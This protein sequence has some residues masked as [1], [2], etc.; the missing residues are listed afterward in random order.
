MRHPQGLRLANLLLAS[1]SVGGIVTAVQFWIRPLEGGPESALLATLAC[2]ISL[3]LTAIA[4]IATFLAI[5][6]SDRTRVIQT[7]LSVCLLLTFPIGTA[8][9]LYTLWACWSREQRTKPQRWPEA[10]ASNRPFRF[11]PR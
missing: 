1:A 9:S 3:S 11:V 4:A 5:G 7:G 10:S 8:Y 6:G 2:L